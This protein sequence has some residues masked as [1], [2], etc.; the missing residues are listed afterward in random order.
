MVEMKNSVLISVLAAIAGIA[1]FLVLQFVLPTHKSNAAIDTL[2][3]LVVI[4]N[5]F[6]FSTKR[7]KK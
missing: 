2:I 3:L 7:R 1:C 6:Y 4:G 5:I